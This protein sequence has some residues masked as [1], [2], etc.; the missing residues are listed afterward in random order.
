MRTQCVTGVDVIFLARHIHTEG[1]KVYITSTWTIT[2]VNGD[3]I[4]LYKSY[5]QE[6][7]EEEHENL[8]TKLIY[9]VW[10]K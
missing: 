4:L 2:I 1:H 10:S 7:K 8:Q 6:K 9:I 3:D 5:A